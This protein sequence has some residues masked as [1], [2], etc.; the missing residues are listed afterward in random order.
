MAK[1]NTKTKT[2]KYVL[3]RVELAEQLEEILDQLND[4]DTNGSSPVDVSSEIGDVMVRLQNIRDEIT[5]E[6]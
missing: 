6:V 4:I 5:T 2:R 1:K 3:T